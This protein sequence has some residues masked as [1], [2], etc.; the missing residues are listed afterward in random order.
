MS[1]TSIAPNP[2]FNPVFRGGAFPEAAEATNPRQQLIDSSL[3]A[4]HIH[5]SEGIE[6]DVINHEAAERNFDTLLVLTDM[7]RSRYTTFQLRGDEQT[8]RTWGPT[9]KYDWFFD[10]YAQTG[11]DK[12]QFDR[13]SKIVNL[14]LEKLGPHNDMADAEEDLV[15]A[16]NWLIGVDADQRQAN[17]NTKEV[18]DKEFGLIADVDLELSELVDDDSREDYLREAAAYQEHYL[19][20]QE[21]KGKLYTATLARMRLGA[22]RVEL[23]HM[24]ALGTSQLTLNYTSEQYTDF[25]T[26]VEAEL[27]G[28]NDH[29]DDALDETRTRF[30]EASEQ[31]ANEK[32]L[33]EKKRE[34]TR[35]VAALFETYTYLRTMDTIISHDGLAFEKFRPG[36]AHEEHATAHKIDELPTSR[37]LKLPDGTIEE[38]APHGF[39][40]NFDFVYTTLNTDSRPG[41]GIYHTVYFQN[42]INPDLAP[43][44]EAKAASA[45]FF[46]GKQFYY[47]EP[48]DNIDNFRLG[49]TPE[50]TMTRLVDSMQRWSAGE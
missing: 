48:N 7:I 39:N 20:Q 43:A 46:A 2:D 33:Q 17:Q 26:A 50:E 21:A 45:R 41:E 44:D 12:G 49:A 1:E 36:N 31:P 40:Y 28:L 16:R 37:Q 34:F 9:P 15:S 19:A 42:K 14:W 27:E 38:L 4:Y 24:R 8:A 23:A 30:M 35:T 3:S 32:Q 6:G 25:K 47:V 11:I 18:T 22:T 10:K 29:F 5:H 13:P